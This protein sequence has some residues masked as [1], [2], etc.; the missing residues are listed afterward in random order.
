MVT[1]ETCNN[2][3]TPF[4]SQSNIYPIFIVI[5]AEDCCQDCADTYIGKVFR[6]EDD[7][8][9][10]PPLHNGCVCSMVYFASKLAADEAAQMV[11]K[12]R[13]TRKIDS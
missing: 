6:V 13:L 2:I 8:D 11:E 7:K 12:E 1:K 4:Q 3:Q 9:M 10:I 5:C